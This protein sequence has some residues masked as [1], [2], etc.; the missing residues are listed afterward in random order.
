MPVTIAERFVFARSEARI[1]GSNPT[2]D[3]DVWCLVFV[4]V[5]VCACFCVC[6]QVET[7]RRPDHPSK[8]SYRMSKI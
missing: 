5:C 4:C 1:V 2:Q 8:E 7:L 6:V 3:M